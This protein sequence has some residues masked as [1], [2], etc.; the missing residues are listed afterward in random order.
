M[1]LRPQGDQFAVDHRMRLSV[2]CNERTDSCNMDKVETA[3][4]K[5]GN[6]VKTYL[7]SHNSNS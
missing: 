4:V 7:S 5:C 6:S 3:Q 2:P 1:T